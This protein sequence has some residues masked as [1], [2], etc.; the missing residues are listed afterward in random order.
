MT[1]TY[2]S[3]ILYDLPLV[4][5][6]CSPTPRRR[7]NRPNEAVGTKSTHVYYTASRERNLGASAHARPIIVSRIAFTRA[8]SS[9][10]SLCTTS[11][12][13]AARSFALAALTAFF[14]PPCA[15]PWDSS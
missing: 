9:S 5:V 7:T 8:P 4:Y 12:S 14:S 11:N 10:T 6:M 3:D 15:S 13:G 1:K 2:I